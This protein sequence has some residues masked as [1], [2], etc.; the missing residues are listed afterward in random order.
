MKVCE[1]AK[2]LCMSYNALS[3]CIKKWHEQPIISHT[4]PD[5]SLLHCI[6]SCTATCWTSHQTNLHIATKLCCSNIKRHENLPANVTLVCL[7]FVYLV[8]RSCDTDTASLPAAVSQTHARP[9]NQLRWKGAFLTF[10]FRPFSS[11]WE[12]KAINNTF[13]LHYIL[14]CKKDDLS[15]ISVGLA[16]CCM[17]WFFLAT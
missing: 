6:L 4:G 1:A 17:N 10:F 14:D 11:F 13:K 3:S 15:V 16:G 5:S 8:S 2:H 9:S 12:H 7:Q